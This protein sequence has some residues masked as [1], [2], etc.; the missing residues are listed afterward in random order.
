[1]R[2]AEVIPGKL[3]FAVVGAL[4]FIN[5]NDAVQGNVIWPL[6]PFA[7]QRWGFP[8][9]EVGLGVGI[10]ASSFFIA[11]SIAFPIWGALGDR[12][13]RRPCMI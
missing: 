1:M 10:L 11:Q 8:P 7:V 5:F 3:D 12:F 4:C 9:E 6:L 2:P 13:G